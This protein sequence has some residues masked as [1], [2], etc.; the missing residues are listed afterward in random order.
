MLNIWGS[1]HRLCDRINR[2]EFLRIGSF[3]VGGL[4]LADL[5]RLR[6]QGANGL[7]GATAA[8][9]AKSVIMIYLPGGPSH[10]DM[11]DMKPEAP[12]EFR[13]EFQPIRTS[14]PGLDICEHMP[15]QAQMAEKMTVVR[16]LRF[17]GKH[18]GYEL[19]SGYP[20]ARSGEIRT[21]EKWPVFGSVVSRIRAEQ[22]TTMPPYVNL[23]DLRL[24]LESDD[25]EVPRYLGTAHA[26]FRPSGPGLANLRLPEGV[27]L[28]RLD[29]RKSLLAGFDQARRTADST[30]GMQALDEFQRRAFGMVASGAVY[31][32]LDLNRED[33]R[34]RERY[35][36]CTNLLL[37]RR[38]VEAGVSVVTVAQ[39][40]VE[41]PGVPVQGAWDT[42]KNNFGYMEKTLPAYDRAVS[43]LISDIYARGLDQQVA[44]VIWGEFGRTP[45]IGTESRTLGMQYS[46]GRDHWWDAGFAVFVGGGLRMGQVIGETDGRAERPK[47][48]PYTPQNVLA[49][50]YQVLG[51]DPSRTFPDYQ[52]RPVH[53]LDDRNPIQEL[54]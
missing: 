3:G 46:V 52:G 44:V 12:I 28:Q 10:I 23:N 14:L 38:L 54:L 29:D 37:A 48:R 42:H 41:R 5:L 19:L 8:A 2:R 39:G 16:G 43:T 11:Y 17:R 36:G 53:L 21:A 20:S 22:A 26:P 45:R 13:G 15:L 7:T 4:T 30:E 47:G 1:S 34:T 35:Q 40:G 6:A 24:S 18:D 49:T 32:A 9:P 33:P 25:P 27:S 50:L 51:I 31:D